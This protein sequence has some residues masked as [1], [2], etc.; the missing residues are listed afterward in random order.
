MVPEPVPASTTTSTTAPTDGVPRPDPTFT[1]GAAIAGVSAA[2]V[3]VS[4]YSKS[5]RNVPES[6]KIAVFREYGIDPARSSEYEV[7]HLIS[8]E[9]GGSNDITNLWPEPYASPEGARVKDRV[10]NWLH[11]QVCAGL[12]DLGT[13]QREIAG[14]WYGTWVAAGRP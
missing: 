2:Q 7:D 3:C 4:G 1:P 8:L 12:I 9:L 13:A 6:E 11:R 10:E 14:D 5:V